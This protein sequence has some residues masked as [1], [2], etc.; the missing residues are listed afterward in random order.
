MS[1]HAHSMLMKP[2]ESLAIDTNQAFSQ[3]LMITRSDQITTDLVHPSDELRAHNYFLHRFFGSA[4]SKW[5]TRW[6]TTQVSSN[7]VGYHPECPNQTVQVWYLWGNTAFRY[8][9]LAREKQCMILLTGHLARILKRFA[10]ESEFTCILTATQSQSDQ[11]AST[12]FKYLL[13]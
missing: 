9:L 11:A 2:F 1:R 5:V 12:T 7:E 6:R 10:E 13:K 4:S 3:H 8:S